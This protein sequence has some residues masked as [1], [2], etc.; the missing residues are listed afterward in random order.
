MPVL[1][2]DSETMIGRKKERS[3][4]RAVKIGNLTGL[5][6]IRKID[7][8]PNARIRALC[9]VAKGVDESVLRWFGHIERMEKDRIAK[10]LWVV[11]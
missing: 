6:G 9:G 5:L 4:I 10:R 7:S 8:V 3:K 1:L 11:A 2:Y